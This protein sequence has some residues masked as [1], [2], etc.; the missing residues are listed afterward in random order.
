MNLRFL[1]SLGGP[2]RRHSFFFLVLLDLN[3][4]SLDVQNW[5]LDGWIPREASLGERFLFSTIN[6]RARPIDERAAD[7]RVQGHS[8]LL[9]RHRRFWLKR[10]F[11]DFL[12]LSDEFTLVLQ[13]LNVLC[14][15]VEPIMDAICPFVAAFHH[16]FVES[17]KCF[18]FAYFACI[19][20]E[21]F[22]ILLVVL[23]CIENR[24]CR[25]EQ[26]LR[27]VHA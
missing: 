17:L 7:P 19:L 9:L 1:H 23:N 2:V 16:V 3:L 13:L 5:L 14:F 15:G 26:L 24:R 21:V 4:V 11:G 10:A 22:F 18:S 20:F 6:L 25:L 27:L 12:R 8:Y